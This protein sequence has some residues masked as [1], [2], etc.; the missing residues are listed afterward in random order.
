M[1]VQHDMWEF[2]ELFK[3]SSYS[4]EIKSDKPSFLKTPHTKVF[5]LEY[6]RDPKRHFMWQIK[7][8]SMNVNNYNNKN[9]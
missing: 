7:L 8:F 4:S 1:F 9:A 5:I 2:I 3:K 6:S